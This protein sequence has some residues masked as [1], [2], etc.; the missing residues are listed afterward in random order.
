[1]G[2]RPRSYSE[3]ILSQ[4]ADAA[5]R[6]F[7]SGAAEHERRFTLNAPRDQV[8]D[9][10][11]RIVGATEFFVFTRV[12]ERVDVHVTNL[13][14]RMLTALYK[15][16]APNIDK[17]WRNVVTTAVDLLDISISQCASY[18]DVMGYVELRNAAMHG[19]GS[20]TR[21]QAKD[22]AVD[23]K[24]RTIGVSVS[25][26]NLILPNSIVRD[27]AMHCRHFVMS[28]DEITWTAPAG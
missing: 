18:G 12:I 8:F 26:R 15:K 5:C 3:S 24:L 9:A 27:A 7:M 20:L 16:E 10:I 6:S 28:V 23:S 21:R 17:T 11:V 25:D 14:D 13:N 22:T 1:M 4:T 2:V 19:R